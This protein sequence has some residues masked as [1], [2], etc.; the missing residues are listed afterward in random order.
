MLGLA[1]L[2]HFITE[3]DKDQRV[4]DQLGSVWYRM[5]IHEKHIGKKQE[6]GYVEDHVPG[7]DHEGRGEEGHI[8]PE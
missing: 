3:Q 5:E 7:E 8:V 4:E 2:P 6:K 1:Y